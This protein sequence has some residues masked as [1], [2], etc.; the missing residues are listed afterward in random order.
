VHMVDRKAIVL[1]AQG[2]CGI[3]TFSKGNGLVQ[4]DFSR[5]DKALIHTVPYNRESSAPFLAF[6][7]DWSCQERGSTA[8]Y[9]LRQNGVAQLVFPTPHLQYV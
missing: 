9:L 4:F 5:G 2:D 6:E 8:G 1:S 7:R 3:N